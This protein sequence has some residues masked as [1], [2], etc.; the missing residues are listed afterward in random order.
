MGKHQISKGYIVTV[1][2]EDDDL[3]S[4]TWTAS[5]RQNGRVYVMRIMPR[6]H[7]PRGLYLHRAIVARMG[8]ICD[9]KDIDHK[10][11]DTLDNRRANLRAVA[12]RENLWN[13]RTTKSLSGVRG[14]VQR[15]PTRFEVSIRDANGKRLWLGS[16][17][18]L[19][20]GQAVRLRAEKEMWGIQPRRASAHGG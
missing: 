11:G 18:T 3:F 16:Y 19:E 10:N 15:T 17:K 2:D 8:V 6:D 12:H 5:E 20:E 13:S 7:K 9:G 4:L 14:V 1:D